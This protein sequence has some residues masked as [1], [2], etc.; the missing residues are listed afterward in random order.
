MTKVVISE[1]IQRATGCNVAQ[2]KKAVDAV[3]GVI[4][5]SLKKDGRFGLKGFGTFG[6][7]KRGRRKG[8]NPR[9]AVCNTALHQN[10]T[11]TESASHVRNWEMV[12]G[13]GRVY[14]IVDTA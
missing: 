14:R 7:V 2:A 10:Q 12:D 3:T 9:A 11:F 4:A 5:R 8:R 6:V 13:R 1:A